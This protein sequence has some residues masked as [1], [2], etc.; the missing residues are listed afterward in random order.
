MQIETKEVRHHE[1]SIIIMAVVIVPILIAMFW[2]MEKSYCKKVR[3][4]EVV[5][6][7][8]DR[9]CDMVGK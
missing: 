4:G 9:Y 5:R 7:T 2:S 6:L 1:R 3:S 8:D